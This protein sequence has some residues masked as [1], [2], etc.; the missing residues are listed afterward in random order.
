MAK[1]LFQKNKDFQIVH[2]K[3]IQ[4]QKNTYVLSTTFNKFY[5]EEVQE[6]RLWAS[7]VGRGCQHPGQF[8]KLCWLLMI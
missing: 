8:R 5:F 4:K 2:L 6:E 1:P 7:A 3:I